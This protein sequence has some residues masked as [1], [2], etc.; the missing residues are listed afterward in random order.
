MTITA[1]QIKFIQVAK[2]KLKLDDDIYR[3]ALV[4]IA[5]VTSSK[6]LDGQ[7][8]AAMMGFFEHLGFKPSTPRGPSFGNR[9][10]HGK[11]CAA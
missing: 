3:T 5:G 7:G 10:R 2:S 11:L 4:Q 8:Y 6:E 1:N 9:P